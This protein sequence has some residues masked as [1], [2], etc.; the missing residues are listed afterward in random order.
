MACHGQ[1]YSNSCSG[2]RNRGAWAPHTFHDDIEIKLYNLN[3]LQNLFKIERD[4]RNNHNKISLPSFNP[5]RNAIEILRKDIDNLIYIVNKMVTGD[6]TGYPNNDLVS[7]GVSTEITHE[8]VK[9]KF[10]DLQNKVNQLRVDCI[11]HGDC[12]ANARCSCNGEC[13]CNCNHY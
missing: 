10:I 2:H 3:E 11:C 4:A 8:V 12:G 9:S 5:S 13:R 7:T 6:P 1:C